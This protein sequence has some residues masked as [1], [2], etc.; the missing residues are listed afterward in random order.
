M[1][2]WLATGVAQNYGKDLANGVIGTLAWELLGV[3]GLIAFAVAAIRYSIDRNQRNPFRVLAV[4]FGLGLLLQFYGFV[5]DSIDKSMN[6]AARKVSEKGAFET[7]SQNFLDGVK[8][9]FTIKVDPSGS[10]GASAAQSSR[11]DKVRSYWQS[12]KNFA[13]AVSDDPENVA[14]QYVTGALSGILSTLTVFLAI[15]FFELFSVLRIAIFQ[16][17]YAVGPLVIA[18]SILPGAFTLL[19]RWVSAVFE[20]CSWQLIGAIVFELV[21]KSS[22]AH[23]YASDTD[24]FIPLCVA[25][26]VFV[27][28]IVLIPVIAHRIVGSGFSALGQSIQ[29][30]VMSYSGAAGG[31]AVGG[32]QGA[33]AAAT[34]YVVKGA[35][36]LA[37]Q[38]VM[39]ADRAPNAVNAPGVREAILASSNPPDAAGARAAPMSGTPASE[40]VERGHHSSQAAAKQSAESKRGES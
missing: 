37:Q 33:V 35:G 3:A 4:V 16:V 8:K 2:S 38:A 29:T 15:V 26:L 13:S 21:A 39:T 31:M 7:F 30:T 23:V 36:A 40:N 9:R 17:L 24:N 32:V 18:L 12:T 28:A 11:W 19:G 14:T 20:V 22:A 34:P 6:I 5:A 27:C 10:D 1:K 25:N